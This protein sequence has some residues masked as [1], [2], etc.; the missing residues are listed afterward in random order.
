MPDKRSIVF[1]LRPVLPF[2][3]LWALA[4]YPDVETSKEFHV[5]TALSAL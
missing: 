3:D 2:E 5:I 4:L 1:P